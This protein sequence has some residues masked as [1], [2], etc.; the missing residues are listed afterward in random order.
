MKLEVDIN[1]LENSVKK[2]EYTISI[3]KKSF[4]HIKVKINTASMNWE[5]KD[6]QLFKDKWNGL[7]NKNSEFIKEQKMMQSYAEY[8]K[9]CIKDYSK[10][11]GKAVTRAKKLPR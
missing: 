3:Q 5:G 9:R 1:K 7:I 11:K 8:L 2:I 4:D 6:A 10:I